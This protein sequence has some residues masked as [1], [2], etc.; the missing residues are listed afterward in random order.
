MPL[1]WWLIF[2]IDLGLT[3]NSSFDCYL[4][5]EQSVSVPLTW[6]GQTCDGPGLN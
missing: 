3:L 6:A 2:S 5:P 4:F 1:I